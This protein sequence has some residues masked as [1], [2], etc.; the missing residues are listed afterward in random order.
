M[1]AKARTTHEIFAGD[2]Y[3]IPFFQRFYSWEPK[4]WKRLRADVWSLME[5]AAK[6]QH[7]LGPLVCTP[8]HHEPGEIPAYLLIDGQQRLTTLT[9]MLVAL[10]DVCRE[11]GLEPLANKIHQGY[12]VYE[13]ELGI[14][15]YKIIPRIGDRELLIAI[16]EGKPTGS[17][18]ANVVRAYEYFRKFTREWAATNAESQLKRLFSAVVGQL[19]LVVITIDGEN[20][21]EIFESLNSTG[22]PLEESD[23]IRNFLFMQVPMPQQ[24]HFHAEHWAPFE[25]MWDGFNDDSSKIQTAFY[26]NYV[27]RGGTYSRAKS[28]FVDFKDQ[29]K[30]SGLNPKDQVA[31]L[32]RYALYELMVREP[33]RCDSPAIRE[34]LSRIALLDI[35]TAH[36]LLMNL[37]DQHSRQLLDEATLCG[38][39]QDLGSFVVRRSI[40]GET[41]RPYGRWF[42]EAIR[43]IKANPRDDLRQYWLKRGWPD[44]AA[45]TANLV[46]FALYRREGKKCRL[47]LEELERSFGHK[48]KV[49]PGTLSIEHVMP[50]TINDDASGKAWQAM[51]GPEWK[52]VHR[53]WLHTLGNLTLTG[54]NSPMGNQPFE[55]KQVELSNSKLTL[56]K[57][58]ALVKEWNE[59][60]IRQRGRELAMQVAALWPRPADVT[61]YVP[62]HT[63]VK[64]A[65]D[66]KLVMAFWQGL[67]AIMAERKLFKKLPKPRRYGWLLFPVGRSGIRLTVFRNPRKSYIGVGI[68]LRGPKSVARFHVLHDEKAA[69]ETELGHGLIWGERPLGQ[70][71]LILLRKEGINLDDQTKWPELYQWVAEKLAL[72]SKVFQA[73]IKNLVA[74]PEI[75]NVQIVQQEYWTVLRMQLADQESIVKLHKPR[76]QHWINCSIG[77]ARFGL[78][79]AMSHKKQCISVGFCCYGPQAKKN[80]QLLLADKE[81]IE[82]EVGT[83][84][85]WEELPLRKESRIAVRRHGVDPTNRQAWTEQHEWLGQMLER[86]HKVFRARAKALSPNGKK[87]PGMESDSKPS[88]IE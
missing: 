78:F 66:G 79:A 12:L 43:Q 46:D 67:L 51:L 88:L 81:A 44:D 57:H 61:P 4:H 34:Q 19:S 11:Y 14:H 15:R 68:R 9:L 40:C 26:R 72:M 80:F 18:G 58:F 69:I 27:M 21:Y 54:Y 32:L 22:L 75:G 50:Q 16:I 82:K 20:P 63:K 31:E 77:A 7:F 10:R 13:H 35:A 59:Q 33:S 53:T 64:K 6:G 47:I 62:S 87:S 52:A 83:A 23:L 8:T 39:L 5:E 48:E 84:L 86:F 30:S 70:S 65:S 24:E 2:R 36:P 29:A 56:N 45:F 76:P 37:M 25:G 1:D 74:K 71:S 41:T 55:K 38:C 49:D 3:L 42:C 17:E 85:D 60:T 73:R 28:T